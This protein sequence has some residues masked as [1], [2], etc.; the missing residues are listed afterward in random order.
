MAEHFNCHCLFRDRWLP[1]QPPL[2][3]EYQ[4]DMGFS[5]FCEIWVWDKHIGTISNRCC[6]VMFFQLLEHNINLT[7][8]FLLPTYHDFEKWIPHLFIFSVKL[9]FF[10]Y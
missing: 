9:I 2:L 1:N 10:K 6:E 5:Y 4:I 7:V 3:N 8:I